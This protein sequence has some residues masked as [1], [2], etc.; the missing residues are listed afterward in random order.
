MIFLQSY[1]SI[2]KVKSYDLTRRNVLE[3][4]KLCEGDATA[5]N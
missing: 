3:N 2:I 5:A 4:K 1:M